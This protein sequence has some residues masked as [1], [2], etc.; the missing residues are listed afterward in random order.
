MV[1]TKLKHKHGL[2][3]DLSALYFQANSQFSVIDYRKL[4]E[5][6]HADVVYGF[7]TAI[8]ENEG[9]TTFNKKL[10]QLGVELTILDARL[11]PHIRKDTRCTT[12][13]AYALG[14]SEQMEEI[15]V[16]SPDFTLYPALNDLAAA[17]GTKVVLAFPATGLDHMW[18]NQPAKSKIAVLDLDLKKFRPYF[19]EEKIAETHVNVG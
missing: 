5:Y 9:Q 16:V 4:L 15:T 7:T 3:L 11:M 6:F 1:G 18:G 19:Y 17:Y 14:L 2:F 13:L 10:K 12:L 8:E